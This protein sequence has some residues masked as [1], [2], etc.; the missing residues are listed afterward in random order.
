MFVALRDV[1]DNKGHVDRFNMDGTGRIHTTL[2]DLSG[3]ISLH[4]DHDLNRIFVAA[5]GSG[6][7]E[8]TSIE[9]N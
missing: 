5:A 4:F 8:S 9:G 6:I 7:I 2:E 1:D 3:P